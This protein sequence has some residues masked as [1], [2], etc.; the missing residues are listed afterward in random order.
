MERKV[1]LCGIAMKWKCHVLMGA[2]SYQVF[3]SVH[4]DFSWLPNV[5]QLLLL[6]CTE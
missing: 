3:M 6:F 5:T 1:I 2:G 4:S